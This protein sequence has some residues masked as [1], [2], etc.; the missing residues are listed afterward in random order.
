MIKKYLEKK[1]KIFYNFSLSDKFKLQ[2]KW[3]RE[4]VIRVRNLISS[5]YKEWKRR[6]P[7]NQWRKKYRV[8]WITGGTVNK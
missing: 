2:R 8:E 1:Y 6:K 4:M 3:G 5:R 7:T